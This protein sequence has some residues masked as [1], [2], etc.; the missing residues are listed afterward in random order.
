MVTL[1]R[2]AAQ[3]GL[4]WALFAVATVP[5]AADSGARPTAPDWTGFYI[6][7][8]AGGGWLADKSPSA[9]TLTTTPIV[10]DPANFSAKTGAG[11]IGGVQ[12][13]YNWQLSPSWLVGV[14]GDFSL[15]SAANRFDSGGLTS[16]GAPLAATNYVTMNTRLNWLAS[17]RARAGYS[18]DR[19]M[20]YVTGGVAWANIA[21]DA[22]RNYAAIA[23][24]NAA[25]FTATSQGWVIGGGAEYAASAHLM[26][27]AEYLYYSLSSSQSVTTT[28]SGIFCGVTPPVIAYSWGNSAVHV[29]RIGLSYKF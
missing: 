8:H 28:C 15:A 14:E 26:L 5:A 18:W 9:V 10:V 19:T 20:L 1:Q 24:N 4:A 25:S 22:I 27:R 16:N 11:A 3:A 12:A 13:G 2:A 23:P 29:A 7:G 6:G 17:I 21:Y